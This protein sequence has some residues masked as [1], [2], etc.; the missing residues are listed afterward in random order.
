MPLPQ[1]IYFQDDRGRSPFMDW[2]D[3]SRK[4]PRTKWQVGS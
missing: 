1:V 3:G 2:L 4:K